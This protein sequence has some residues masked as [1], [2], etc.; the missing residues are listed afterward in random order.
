MFWFSLHLSETSP[1]KNAARYCHKCTRLHVQYLYILSNFNKPWILLT[2]FWKI[3]NHQISWK[4]VQWEPSCS[5]WIQTDRTMLTDA[6]HNFMDT[7]KE[8]KMTPTQAVKY[9]YGWRWFKCHQGLHF[10]LLCHSRVTSYSLH[11]TKHLCKLTIWSTE[12]VVF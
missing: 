9:N 6:F 3:L 4:S 2:D 11:Y 1:F 12:F 7:S 10:S 5:M 8:D